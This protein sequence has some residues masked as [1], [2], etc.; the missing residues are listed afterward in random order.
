MDDPNEYVL[1]S[2]CCFQTLDKRRDHL[3]CLFWKNAFL[4]LSFQVKSA[5][6]PQSTV[7]VLGS[8]YTFQEEVFRALG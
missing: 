5:Q 3:F 4:S 8:H 1:T 7:L 6:S 2:W